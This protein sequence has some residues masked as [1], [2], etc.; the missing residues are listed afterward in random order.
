MSI[1][2]EVQSFDCSLCACVFKLITLHCDNLFSEGLIDC[3][4]YGSADNPKLKNRGFAFLEYDSHKSAST[5]KR[6]LSTGRVK[7]WQCAIIVDW[8]DPQEEPDEDT[9]A[10]VWF[11]S[12]SLS[13]FIPFSLSN[14]ILQNLTL[15]KLNFCFFCYIIKI[16]L[17]VKF[18]YFGQFVK[19][20]MREIFFF[21]TC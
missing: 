16:W 20:I 21:M 10:K 13:F 2:C 19:E 12:L 6:K 17:E 11:L 3:I 4:V 18:M 9:M 1:H 7:V 8:A 15:I 5:A 14:C